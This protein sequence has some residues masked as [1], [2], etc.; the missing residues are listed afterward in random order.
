MFVVVLAFNQHFAHFNLYLC[1][2]SC[3]CTCLV[4]SWNCASFICIFLCS[5][6]VSVFTAFSQRFALFKLLFGLFEQLLLLILA[7]SNS[8]QHSQAFIIIRP[9]TSPKIQPNK[10]QKYQLKTVEIKTLLNSPQ[11]LNRTKL[12]SLRDTLQVAA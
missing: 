6:S 4:L 8:T 12:C 7:N 1:S 9:Q 3:I 2:F 11:V 10:I 5:A